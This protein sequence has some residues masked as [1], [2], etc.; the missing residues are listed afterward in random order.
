LPRWERWGTAPPYAPPSQ[1]Q[2]VEMLK[3]EAQWLKEQL[4]TINKRMDE[5]SQQ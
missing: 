4:D 2:E 3:D 1:E 5:L